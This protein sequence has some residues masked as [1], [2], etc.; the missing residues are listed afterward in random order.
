MSRQ[1]FPRLDV[2]EAT[3]VGLR[4]E[5]NED[6][7][8]VII[9]PPNTPQIAQGALFL[10]ADGMGGLGGGALASQS[11]VEELIRCYYSPTPDH[12]PVQDRL[13]QALEA[14]NGH[15]RNQAARIGLRRIGTTMTGLVLTADEQA[16]VFNIGDSRVYHL[17]NGLIEQI[18]RDHSVMALQIE[19]GLITEEQARLSRNCNITA[20]IGQ[21]TPL[22]SC[23]QPI[24][25]HRGDVFV[26][27]S[28]GLW[29]V[30]ETH[31]IYQLVH[32]VP[33]QQGVERLVQLALQRGA[34]DNV[35]VIV[36]RVG[37]P[38]RRRFWMP[39]P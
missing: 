37:N 32:Q 26:V 16:L 18:T 6:S 29:S 24:P 28:D 4:R 23:V 5:R 34:P 8:S 33:A 12:A 20:F 38:P 9:P 25:V 1:V 22:D 19:S 27:C 30:M 10:V 31:E 21:P 35:S 15:V 14:A 2:A 13:Q 3:D 39:H 17:R 36:V 11:A 7:L